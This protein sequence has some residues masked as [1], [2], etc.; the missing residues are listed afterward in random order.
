MN[1]SKMST[2]FHD[3]LNQCPVQWLRLSYDEINE[4]ERLII[5]SHNLRIP[6]SS[7]YQF[8]D[9]TEKRTIKTNRR[10]KNE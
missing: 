10:N 2:E 6:V 8:I 9:T 1:I 3:W 7:V 5:E 4:N